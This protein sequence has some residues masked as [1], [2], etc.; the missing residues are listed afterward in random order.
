MGI[1]DTEKHK[2]TK[3][4]ANNKNKKPGNKRFSIEEW[5]N[6]YTS[7]MVVVLGERDFHP[8]NYTYQ[9]YLNVQ[10]KIILLLGI[11]PK[12]TIKTA[13]NNSTAMIDIQTSSYNKKT[14]KYMKSFK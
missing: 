10:N 5:I 12:E 14:E 9:K 4:Y 6:Y 3:V 7:L 11:Y 2:Q 13:W 1:F 8:L